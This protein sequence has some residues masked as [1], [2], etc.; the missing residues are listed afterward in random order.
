[1]VDP[2][3]DNAQTEHSDF[4]KKRSAFLEYYNRE[5]SYL[6]QSSTRFVH[7]HERV[8]E[9][10]GLKPGQADDPHVERLLDSF[11][12]LAARIHQRLDDEFPEI[13][14]ALLEELY[15]NF[16]RPIPSAAIVQFQTDV[17]GSIRSGS[18][19]IARGTRLDS[20]PFGGFVCRFRTCFD[21]EVWPVNIEHASWRSASTLPPALVG[22][23]T[24][25][26][27]ELRIACS[28]DVTF[29]GLSL[30]KL[31]LFLNGGN[32][33]V[34]PI[35][36]LLLSQ[37]H[38]IWFQDAD[39]SGIPKTFPLNTSALSP[40][41]F[42]DEDSLFW[43]PRDRR[44]FS[45]YRLLEDYFAF[46]HKFLFLDLGQLERIAEAG[47]QKRASILF[48][49]SPFDRREW[50]S[51]LEQGVSASNF[52]LN[53]TPAVNLFSTSTKVEMRANRYE[54]PILLD[55][56]CEAYSVDQIY[57][58]A[59]TSARIPFERYV[60]CGNGP[61]ADRAAAFWNAIRRTGKNQDDPSEMYLSLVDRVGSRV[62]PT[63]ENLV[64]ILTCTNRNLPS[65]LKIGDFHVEGHPE[66]S[67]IVVLSGPTESAAAASSQTSLWR[68]LSQLSLN[69]LS[70][71]EGG[72]QALQ[73]ILRIHN[74]SGKESG[75]R[76]IDSIQAVSSRPH[77]GRVACEHGLTFVRGKRV[78]V[79]IG[80]G[81]FSEGGAFL[82]GSI[83]D[84]FLGLYTSLNS[85]SQLNLISNQRGGKSIHLW[86]ARSGAK[87]VL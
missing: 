66:I 37:C 78:D 39:E 8:A 80:E 53:C 4:Y 75:E 63:V 15:P 70:L 20:N 5:L 68:L 77:F 42:G 81:I 49:I 35:Y 55:S 72:R 19:K 45:G 40:G 1:M 10:L 64:A 61:I 59:P 13:T 51:V 18:R 85:F 50:Q 43:N 79:T 23:Q 82:F 34:Y 36:E 14:G 74:L 47:I 31:R 27:L 44:T 57:G 24:A 32:G 38:T 17:E 84:R 52:R 48:L 30:D 46:P 67:R 16:L 22:Q 25:A 33:V 29:S 7:D 58:Q 2:T 41:G 65:E 73:A 76:Q 28:P 26:V 60:D 62:Y 54:M 9:S 83:L 3:G 86:P 56:K 11:A 69:H 12:F 71:V 6:R 21:T 87:V